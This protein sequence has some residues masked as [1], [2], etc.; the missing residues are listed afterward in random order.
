MRLLIIAALVVFLYFEFKR[1]KTIVIEYYYDGPYQ[2][3]VVN[4]LNYWTTNRLNFK[5][6]DSI[7]NAYL[8]IEHTDPS[9][10]KKSDWVAQYSPR[11]KTILLNKAYDHVLKEDYLSGAIAH[12]TGHM[13]GL[14][15][16]TEEGS[17]MNDKILS[18]TQPTM[19]DK[20]R[21]NDK[22]T[23]FYYKKL[24]ENFLL[25]NESPDR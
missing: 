12:E 9:R 21:V 2:Q 1:E 15:H 22:L 6:V 25:S 7:D 24:I 20:L 10:I 17:I 13:F 14:Q 19:L 18:N 23:Y 4:G 11:T 8:I 5:Q 3:E 16:N